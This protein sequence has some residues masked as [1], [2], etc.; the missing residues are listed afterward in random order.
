MLSL[1]GRK[2]RESSDVGSF[3]RP[4]QPIV[5]YEFEGCPFCR[6]VREAVAILDLDIEFR[7]CP[8][9]SKWAAG[10]SSCLSSCCRGGRVR[11]AAGLPSHPQCRG[12]AGWRRAD[13]CCRRRRCAGRAHVAARG[14]QQ[15][16][17]EAIPLHG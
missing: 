5:L 12:T 6:K 10:D 1:L 13:L 9:V 11:A 7:P 8:Q 17:Q 3:P 2:L 15:G 4:A 14:H 16:R